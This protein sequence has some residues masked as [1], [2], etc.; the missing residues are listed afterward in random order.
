M[1]RELLQLVLPREKGTVF[2]LAIALA[3]EDDPAR[4]DDLPFPGDGQMEG[5]LRVRLPM[6]KESFKVPGDVAARQIRVKVGLDVRIGGTDDPGCRNNAGGKGLFRLTAR[7]GT[8]R[9]HEKAGAA[10]LF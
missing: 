2:L 10:D 7:R 1:P 4:I 6:G 9:P 3:R 5:K 8:L